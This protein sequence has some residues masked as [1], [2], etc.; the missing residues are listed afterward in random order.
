MAELDPTT[1]TVATR[2]V[3][4]GRPERVPG[5]SISPPLE[6]SSTYIADGP[7]GYARGG[8]RTWTAFED[9]LGSLEGGRAL[10]FASGMGAI[11]A[12]V[13]LVP[14]GG[15]VVAPFHAY[16]GTGGILDLYEREQRLT[17]RRV[18]ISD[19]DAVLAALDG[20]DLLWTESPTNPMLEIADL[21]TLFER[22]RA[23]GVTTVCDNTCL[24]YTSPS[25]R[26]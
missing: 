7:V 5:G 2:L 14:A 19:T 25:P 10:T 21:P 6:L 13:A 20:A 4:G 12:C 17:V 8:N 9:T 24:L 18:D 26:D 1:L 16:N 3:A 11:A 15:T 22:A 23:A